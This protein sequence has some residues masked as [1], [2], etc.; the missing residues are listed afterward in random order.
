[1]SASSSDLSTVHLKTLKTSKH[2]STPCA[3]FEQLF[4]QSLTIATTKAVAEILLQAKTTSTG[5]I[6][7]SARENLIVRL[8]H[9][10]EVAGT[11]PTSSMKPD[12]KVL[13]AY[14]DENDPKLFRDPKTFFSSGLQNLSSEL[15]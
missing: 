8:A 3:S 13:G 2:F 6:S 10:M 4:G 5:P 12:G 11:N 9:V 15:R 7:A 1:M 14:R